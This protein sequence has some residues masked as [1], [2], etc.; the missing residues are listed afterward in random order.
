VGILSLHLRRQYKNQVLGPTYRTLSNKITDVFQMVASIRN[1][2]RPRV[3]E[4]LRIGSW[5]ANARET[6]FAEIKCERRPAAPHFSQADL[7]EVAGA[8]DASRV[9]CFGSLAAAEIG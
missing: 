5:F 8:A 6:G 2:K 4:S 7:N 1:D 9:R 3:E